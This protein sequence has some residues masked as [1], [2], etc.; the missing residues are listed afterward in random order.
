MRIRIA[1]TNLDKLPDQSWNAVVEPAHPGEVQEYL[2]DEIFKAMGLRADSLS[3]SCF[4]WVFIPFVRAFS[5]RAFEFD[6][7]VSLHGFQYT[8][9]AWLRKLIPG[10][11]TRGESQLPTCGSLLIAANHPGTFDGMAIA[12]AIPRDD[13]KMV[14]AANPFFR[15][16]PHTRKSFIYS[17]REPHVRMATLRTALRHLHNGGSLLIFP[18]G[19]L[20]PDPY[21][22]PEAAQ[23]TLA[24]WS[25]SLE[26][27]LHKA[28]QTKLF[29]AINSGFVAPEYINN[30]F[31]Q[32]LHQEQARQKLAEFLQVI[33]QLIFNRVVTNHPGVTFSKQIPFDR[34]AE[35]SE[36]FR[37]LIIDT[38][39][40]LIESVA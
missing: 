10:Y 31:V 39:T 24:G 34:R 6:Q 37:H 20:D 19:R 14:A 40:Q 7:M 29:L 23:K 4:G 25:T 27:I 32:Y 15:G 21:Y 9:Q 17:T 2:I 30:R 11:Q 36:L 13:L 22:F 3:R 16:L 38:A 18:S 5:G 1:M 26:F 28:P 35:N 33:H 12:S 8:T